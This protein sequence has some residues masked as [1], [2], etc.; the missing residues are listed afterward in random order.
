[1]ATRREFLQAAGYCALT[2]W[3]VVTMARSTSIAG[4]DP[5]SVFSLSVCSGDPSPTGVILWTRIDPL[6]YDPGESLRFEIAS[7][8]KFRQIVVSGEIAAAD[9][10]PAA[11]YTARVDLDG[12]LKP[13]KRYAYRFTYRDVTSRTGYCRT[14]PA[15]NSLLLRLR[16]GAITC[17]DYTNGYYG[18]LAQLAWEDVDFVVH[19][20]DFIYES[21]GDPRFQPLPYP[22]RTFT[23]PS[24]ASAA[25]TLEDYRFL[26]RLYRSDPLFQQ[27]LERHTLIVLADDHETANDCYWDYDRDTLG[28][29]DHPLVVNDPNGGDP[30]ALRQLKLSSQQAWSE[31]VPARVVFNP[32]APSVQQALTIY[33]C[34]RFGRLVELFATDERTYRDAPPCGDD[35]RVLTLGCPEQSAPERSMLGATQRE[36]FLNGVAQSSALWKVWAN[37]VFLGQLKLGRRDG[38]RLYINVDAWDGFEA[39]RA[40]LLA[41]LR[42]AGVRNFIALTG[43]LHSYIAAYLKIDYLQRSNAPGRNV[44]GVEFMTPAVTSSN[45]LQQ[46]MTL[47]TPEDRRDLGLSGSLDEQFFVL[48]HLAQSTNPHIHF[49]NSQNWGYSIVEFTPLACT[50]SAYSVDTSVNS[51]DATKRLIRQIRV[52]VNTT[53]MVDVV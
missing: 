17:Q 43:D 7:D 47:L 5:A 22:D 34:F 29:P 51:G 53:R 33:R 30:Q 24:D 19:L 18:P 25:S 9:I 12:H 15:E 11:D 39:E 49:F 6:A 13:M 35:Q 41:R 37:E 16:L 4:S 2:P 32:Q 20:G 23:L 44:V 14:L 3:V 45:L 36:W 21:T 46:M 8:D 31:Y 27:L 10:G 26:Y 38:R 50:Y 48:E 28:A 40:H 52:P 1:M 42:D